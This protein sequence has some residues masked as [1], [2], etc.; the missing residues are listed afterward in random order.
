MTEYRG[1]WLKGSQS[2]S[3]NRQSQTGYPLILF[4]ISSMCHLPRS[5]LVL[6]T[7][8]LTGEFSLIMISKFLKRIGIMESFSVSSMREML[9]K[10]FSSFL[11]IMTITVSSSFVSAQASS[12]FDDIKIESKSAKKIKNGQRI[13]QWATVFGVIASTCVGVTLHNCIKDFVPDN[14]SGSCSGAGSNCSPEY[15]DTAQCNGYMAGFLVASG[16]KILANFTYMCCCCSNSED[17]SKCSRTLRNA[18]R[19]L[20][21]GIG[22]ILGAYEIGSGESVKAV[23]GSSIASTIVATILSAVDSINCG[24]N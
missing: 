4:L 19:L 18:G 21:S 13:S 17:T 12:E 24:C 14:G 7:P 6:L 9:C 10:F 3:T 16:V 8:E 15:N 22:F 5:Y 2:A 23:L 11:L 20:G 1:S